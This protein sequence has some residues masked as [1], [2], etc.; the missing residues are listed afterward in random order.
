M[1]HQIQIK[2]DAFADR[3]LMQV[4]SRAGE[5]YAVWL[6]RRMMQRLWPPFLQLSGQQALAGASPGAVVLPEA[7]AMLAE[8][9]RLRTLP[10]ADFKQPFNADQ[11]SQ[12]L[13]DEPLL[14]AEIELKA[15][16]QRGLWM[17]VREAQGRHVAL[18]MN[19]E[20][21]TA[22]LRLFEQALTS[23]DWNLPRTPAQA[24]AERPAL[25]S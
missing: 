15:D 11:T 20:L 13:G 8:S 24:P 7:R 23:A 4:R 5:V 6:T 10:N 14:A 9:A 1:I 16:P 2:Y 19:E 17:T 25:L 18:Q 3:L 21:H 22:M 12:P